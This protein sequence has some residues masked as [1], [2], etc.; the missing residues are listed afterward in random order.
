MSNWRIVSG[1]ELHDGDLVPEWDQSLCLSV[2]K[3]IQLDVVNLMMSGRLKAGT[4]LA[5]LPTWWSDGTGLRGSGDPIHFTVDAKVQQRKFDLVLSIPGKHL[6]KHLQIRSALALVEQAPEMAVDPLAAHRPGSVL[7]EDAITVVL[8][9]QAS[10]FPI[11]VVDFVES[12]LGPANACWRFELAPM[13]PTLPA[14]ATMRLYVNSLHR[15]FHAAATS[16]EATQAQVAIRSALKMSV[17]EEMLRIALDKAEE[18]ETGAQDFQP[19]STGKVLLELI[20]RVF[21]GRGPIACREGRDQDPG[22]FHAELQA[23]LA[24]FGESVLEGATL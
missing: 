14:M 2:T 13:D 20:D 19:G 1:R 8:E 10:R 23:R 21:P 17:G 24:L 18:L 16:R 4:R 22:R 6:A 3:V 7:W 11:T 12:C 15:T 9:G 5:I